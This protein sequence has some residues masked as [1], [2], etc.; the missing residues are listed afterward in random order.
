LISLT[1]PVDKPVY[2]L[3]ITCGQNVDNFLERSYPQ[4]IH[5]VIHRVIHRQI[6]GK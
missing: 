6:A 5:R 4:D 3:W 1:Y 2:K